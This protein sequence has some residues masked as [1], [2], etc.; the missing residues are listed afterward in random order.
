VVG[1]HLRVHVH[2][3]PWSSVA[4]DVATDVDQG[5]SSVVASD[6]RSACCQTSDFGSGA[7]RA[8][9]G[10]CHVPDVRW[11]GS[12]SWSLL[13]SRGASSVV[14]FGAG[15]F[16]RAEGRG[17]VRSCGPSW[18]WQPSRRAAR[19]SAPSSTWSAKPRRVWAEPGIGGCCGG[20]RV[21]GWP[22]Y[23]A[24]GASAGRGDRAVAPA[25][26][27]LGRGHR[28]RCLELDC[29]GVGRGGLELGWVGR[30]EHRCERVLTRF[31]E[32]D[33]PDG[34]ASVDVHWGA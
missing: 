31:Q 11:P 7:S 6:W 3:R 19:R 18:S 1:P 5:G 17:A 24:G 15:R 8:V 22:G 32:A 29:H 20:G 4:V 16:C 26:G 25:P 12:R 14:S 13:P 30:G 33:R 21:R 27:G 10:A 2:G 23:C 34:G 28:G 9:Q